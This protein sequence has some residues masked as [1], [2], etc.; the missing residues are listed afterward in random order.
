MGALA[1]RDQALANA[2]QALNLLMEA[3]LFLTPHK[4]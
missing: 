4:T 1:D 3:N 2:V